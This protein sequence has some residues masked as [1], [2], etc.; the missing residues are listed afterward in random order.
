[1]R[2]VRSI[3]MG[4]VASAG[5]LAGVAAVGVLPA[6]P[7]LAATPGLE[8]KAGEKIK[9]KLKDGRTVEGVVVAADGASLQVKVGIGTLAFQ[10]A[11]VESI[12][13]LAD[14]AAAPEAGE[15]EKDET[16]GIAPSQKKE[17][18]VVGPDTKK[19]Y[20]INMRGEI[21]RDVSYTPMKQILADMKKVQPDYLVIRVDME[22]AARGEKVEDFDVDANNAFQQMETVAQL[23]TLLIDG[24][25]DDS[26]F[27]KKPQMVVWVRRALGGAAFI[28][29]LSPNIYYTSDSLHGGIGY[30]EL[31]FGNMGDRVVREKQFSLRL[32]R[33]QG[34]AVASGYDRRIIEAMA[35][36]EYVLSYDLVGG[37]PVYQ[38]NMLGQN[39]LTDDGNPDEGRADTIDQIAR[40]TGNDWLTLRAPLAQTLGVSKGTIDSMDELVGELGIERDYKIY[41]DTPT[42]IL[43]QWSRSVSEAELEFRRLWREFGRIE[44]EGETP[45]LR[46]RGRGRQ[47]GLLNDVK[48]LLKKYDE[49]INPRAIRGAPAQWENRI[50][51]M[52][53]EIKQQMRIDKRR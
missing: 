41:G 38:E 45:E 8:V 46:N 37:K 34:L 31:I 3:L 12:E 13:K 47:I 29:F 49:A 22:F 18:A 21:G 40:H 4:V 36:T 6:A 16:P 27:V 20:F 15:G 51:V 42:K 48:D 52:I 28:P 33:A 7:A 14:A 39:L 25:R 43:R 1:M 30:L 2:N 26:G 17:A 32:A 10:R 9:L 23:G 24:I 44:V 11:E 53:E 35:R 50:D 19:V 5:L